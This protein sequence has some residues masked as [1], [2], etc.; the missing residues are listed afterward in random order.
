MTKRKRSLH[1]ADRVADSEKAIIERLRAGPERMRDLAGGSQSH[2]IRKRVQPHLRALLAAGAV[3]RVYLGNAQ[4]FA[5]A[6][7]K[8]GGQWLC[9]YLL[10]NT[11]P[12]AGCMIW[13]GHIDQGNVRITIDGHR[14]NVRRA[15]WRL[16]GKRLQ[17]SDRVGSTCDDPQCISPEHL[18][19]EP[20]TSRGRGKRSIQVRAAVAEGK[21]RGSVINLEIARAIAA[22][23]EREI[24]L[25][26]RYGC[27][28]TTVGS[29]RRGQSW[30]DYDQPMAQLV[31]AA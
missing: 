23:A 11:R 14:F 18:M 27:S 22:S 17:Q 24:D 7:W 15:M 2:H 31:R 1:R 25:A 30:I 6:G 29:I 20:A 28:R 9:D 4:H 21:R 19:L 26:R 13:D 5:L 10:G 16:M 12:D 3:R 8:P